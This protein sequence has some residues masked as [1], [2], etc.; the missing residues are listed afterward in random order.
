[1]AYDSSDASCSVGA[2]SQQPLRLSG[3]VML[4]E[5]QVLLEDVRVEMHCRCALRLTKA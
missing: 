5:A 2:Q 4:A 1:M 3:K